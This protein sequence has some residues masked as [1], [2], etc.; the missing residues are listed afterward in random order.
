MQE[1]EGNVDKR[2]ND[3]GINNKTSQ[4]SRRVINIIPSELVQNVGKE[5]NFLGYF[6][7]LKPDTKT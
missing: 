4:T 3:F 1:V 5:Q 2:K 6:M 7:S